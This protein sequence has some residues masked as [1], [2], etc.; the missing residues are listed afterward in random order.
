MALTADLK[1]EKGQVKK[2]KGDLQQLEEELSEIK[3]E[4][5]ATDKVRVASLLSLS[6]FSSPPSSFLPLPSS[7]LLPPPP[8]SPSHL[9]FSPLPPDT[10]RSEEKDIIHEET[11]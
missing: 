6:S 2:L 5:E 11:V 4:K 10:V 8:P 1:E 7:L 9:S 3:T